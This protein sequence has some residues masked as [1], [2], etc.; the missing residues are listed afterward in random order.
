MPESF[1][2]K[3]ADLKPTALLKERL[4]DRCFPVNFAKF[5]KNTF[6]TKHLWSTAST[7]GLEVRLTL[8]LL[9]YFFLKIEDSKLIHGNEIEVEEDPFNLM[10]YE[11]L[12]HLGYAADGTNQVFLN[13]SLVV[14]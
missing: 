2:N 4:W 1:F 10:I 8:T 14:W 12:S 11:G 7:F 9:A 5:R 13:L 6:L 3:V